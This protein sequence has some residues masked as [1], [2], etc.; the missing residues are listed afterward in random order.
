[1][2]ADYTF[3]MVRTAGSAAKDDVPREQAAQPKGLGLTALALGALVVLDSIR[4][5]GGLLDLLHGSHAPVAV[6]EQLLMSGGR[7]V[8]L[9]FVWHYWKGQDWARLCVL[10]WSFVIAFREIS[11]FIDHDADLAALMSQPLRFFHAVVAV[12]LLYW[13]NT[14][15]VRAWFKRMSATAADLIADHLV[16]KL[17]IAVGK[18][19][20]GWRIAFEHDAEIVLHCPWRVV[21]DDNLAFASAAAGGAANQGAA[22]EDEVRRLLENLRVKAVRLAPSSAASSSAGPRTSDLFLTFE[23]GIEVQTWSVDPRADHWRFSDPLLTVTADGGSLSSRLAE[24]VGQQS[25]TPS[26]TPSVTP[27]ATSDIPSD[28][29]PVRSNHGDND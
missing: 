14:R 11:A 5:F 24:R 23:M 19:G 21:L 16:G 12:F 4:G 25:A 3:G 2:R 17:C 7:V 8:G 20:E 13:L 29:P 10:V 6:I 22:D 9:L 28:T 18:D 15:Q 26:V 1:M 27:S